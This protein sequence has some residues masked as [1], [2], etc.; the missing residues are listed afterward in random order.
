MHLPRL[1][2]TSRDLNIN[3]ETFYGDINF[4]LSKL[5]EEINANSGGYFTTFSSIVYK[6]RNCLGM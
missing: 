2:A 3:L 6:N 5:S 1:L 4:N